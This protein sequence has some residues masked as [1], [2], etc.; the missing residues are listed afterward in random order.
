MLRHVMMFVVGVGLIGLRADSVVAEPHPGP[1]PAGTKAG[2]AAEDKEAKPDYPPFDK[3]T[4]DMTKVVSTVDGSKAL[5]DLYKSEKT[6]KLLGVLPA[7]FDDSLY[8]VASTVSGGD[9]DAGVMGPTHFFKWRK[10]NKQVA[11]IEPDLSVRTDAGQQAKDSIKNL[12]T[13]RLIVTMPI[14]SMAPGNRPVVDLGVLATAKS[15]KFFGRGA[16]GFLGAAGRGVDTSLAAITKA[17]AFPQNVIFEYEFPRGSGDLLRITQSIS[18][19][20]GTPDFKPR[21][22]DPRVGYFYDYHRDYGRAADMDVT[23]RYI[24][25]WHLEKADAELALSPPKQPITWYIEHTTP[26]RF[27]RYVRDGILMWNR[28]FREVGIDNAVVV[29]QQDANT[30]AHMDKDPEDARYN[31]FRW[32]ASNQRYAIGP[33]RSNPMTGEILDADVVWHQ[34]LTRS[35]RGMFE[36]VTGE[37]VARASGPETRAW[38]KDHPE[39][40]PRVRLAAQ[41]RGHAYPGARLSEDGVT[42]DGPDWSPPDS[43]DG[44]NTACQMGDMLAL[45][46][47]LAGAAMDAGLIETNGGALLDGLPESFIGPMI[48]YVSAHEVGHCLGLQH[49]M[50]ASTWKSLK[51]INSGDFE[52][53]MSASVMDY[54]SPNVNDTM[55]D[56]QGP[57]ATDRVGVYDMW[58]IAYGYGPKDKLEEVLAKVNEPGHLFLSQMAIFFGS[59]P[60]NNTWDLGADSLNFATERIGIVKKL[61]ASLLE[62]QVK[63]GDSWKKAR[64]RFNTLAGV[65]VNAIYLASVW[66]GG[67]FINNNF[68]GDPDEQPPVT[69]IPG[70]KQRDALNLVIENS[71]VDDAYGITPELLRHMG[72]EY[73]FDPEERVAFTADPSFPLSDF[74]GNIQATALTLLMNPT[75]L[76]RVYDNEFRAQGDKGVLTLAE[77][78]TT[79]TDA[80]WDECAHA[81]KGKYSAQ[82]PMISGFRRNLQREHLDRLVDL[83]LLDAA[84]SPSLRTVGTLAAS[85]MARIDESVVKALAVRPDPYTQAHLTDIRARIAKAQ[86]ARYVIRQ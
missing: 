19:L 52:G 41:D 40:D 81:K 21:K 59:D 56:T 15:G 86:D 29:Y 37:A 71:F 55:G 1:G 27:R 60:R 50:A 9:P 22:A 36:R 24:S 28:A 48:R 43:P 30:G 35:I 65:Q 51:E 61:R 46:F 73:W 68:K 7:K 34:G 18:K 42:P 64:E 45:E 62:K 84:V 5:I 78:L 3:V 66:V 32:N 10:I 57:Y 39:W 53:A 77:L 82:S 17:K 12:Y 75:K 80:A 83:A 8:M 23:S 44:R 63:E 33:S 38:F 20:V 49:N 11:M 2:D 14:V 67:S 70:D 16:R 79:V 4:K 47:G 69:D 58:A 6:G 26:I 72:R 54:V 13:G 76:R 85:E 31:F 25:R 74:V